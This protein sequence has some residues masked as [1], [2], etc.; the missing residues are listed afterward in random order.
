MISFRVD[1]FD[2]LA[3]QGM[4]KSLHQ[5]HNYKAL[6]FQHSACFMLQF[7]HMY[8]TIG[9]TI[10]LTGQNFVSKVISLLFNMLSSFVIGFLPRSK[11]LLMPWLQSPFTMIWESKKI[12]SVTGSTFFPITHILI[13]YT[14]ISS[15]QSLSHVQLFATPWTAAT[16]LLYPSPTPRVYSNSCTLGWWCHPLSSPSPPAFNLSQHR[17]LFKWVNSSHQ[18]AKVLEFQLQHQSFQ[19]IFRTDFF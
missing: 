6:I 7:S 12:A 8:M 9:K 1:W 17:G 11:S 5:Y 14:Y 15:V 10:P 2:L 16:R 13:I 19:W 3:V 18:V 4:L